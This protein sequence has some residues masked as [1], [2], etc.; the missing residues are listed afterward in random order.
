MPNPDDAWISQ[1]HGECTCH[2]PAAVLCSARARAFRIS[3]RSV[4]SLPEGSGE[5]VPAV[6]AAAAEE[7]RSAT[8]R[9]YDC[10]TRVTLPCDPVRQ[11][12]CKS[13][14]FTRTTQRQHIK[15]HTRKHH[16]NQSQN[17]KKTTPKRTHFL[18]P[19]TRARTHHHHNQTTQPHLSCP[20]ARGGGAPL[21]SW[22]LVAA[23]VLAGVSVGFR[24]ACVTAHYNV[25]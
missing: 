20:N 14:T 5:L 4:A 3:H 24:Y 12:K 7:L 11:Q 17:N 21:T 16:D 2:I 6:T 23:L 10:T 22:A 8:T 15:T 25:K 9:G 19:Q 13:L 18:K 1:R